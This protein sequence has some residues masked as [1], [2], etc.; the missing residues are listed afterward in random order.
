MNKPTYYGM[1]FRLQSESQHS[2][3]V[4]RFNIKQFPVCLPIILSC[5]PC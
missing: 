4:Q 5:I 3:E 1:L 2:F